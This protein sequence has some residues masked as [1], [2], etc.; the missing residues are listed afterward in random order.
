MISST[1]GIHSKQ[2]QFCLTLARAFQRV[3][4]LSFNV[5]H[6]KVKSKHDFGGRCLFGRLERAMT[7]NVVFQIFKSKY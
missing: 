4:E 3:K 6:K 5:C 1:R 7:I 2:E